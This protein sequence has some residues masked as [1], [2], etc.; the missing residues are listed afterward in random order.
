LDPNNKQDLP[1]YSLLDESNNLLRGV[2]DD[3]DTL[4]EPS[5]QFEPLATKAESRSTVT[6]MALS[7]PHDKDYNACNFN[8]WGSRS[9]CMNDNDDDDVRH[10]SHN[11][12]SGPKSPRS[13]LAVRKAMKALRYT[14]PTIASA[15]GKLSTG[16]QQ[17]LGLTHRHQHL[18]DDDDLS[19]LIDS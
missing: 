12:L 6:A 17:T 8:S 11:S 1:I 13:P 9:D 14:K 3:G 2:D 10:N 16:F 18:N 7:M 5:M 19:E 15:V 4:N